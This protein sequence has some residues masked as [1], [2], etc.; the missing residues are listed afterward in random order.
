M[1][2][3]FKNAVEVDFSVEENRVKMEEAFRLVEE[4][5]VALLYT[6]TLIN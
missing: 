6:K 1:L 5:K 3:G 4:E 2:K